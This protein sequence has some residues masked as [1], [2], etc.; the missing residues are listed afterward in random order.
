MALTK[1][2]GDL[3]LSGDLEVRD[4]ITVTDAATIGGNTSVGGTLAVTGITTLSD[5]LVR[6]NKVYVSGTSDTF[7]AITQ[8]AAQWDYTFPDEGIYVVH[9]RG[10]SVFGHLPAT[11][12]PGKM[13]TFLYAGS[14]AGI[15]GAAGYI[16]SANISGN[17]FKSKAD[18]TV[19]TSY[20]IF[21]TKPGSHVSLVNDGTY[22]YMVNYSGCAYF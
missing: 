8:T 16:V 15:L 6:Q 22:Y 17:I 5:D 19:T 12:V 7:T 11:P 2:S 21:M 10:G 1:K 9:G 3:R 18:D 20:G 13:V 14:S 4:D